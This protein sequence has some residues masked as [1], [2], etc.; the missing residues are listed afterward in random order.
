MSASIID[1]P[2]TAIT[3]APDRARAIDTVWAEGLARIIAAQGLRQ[4]ISVR[5]K[6]DGY[7]LVFG[8]HRLEAFRVLGRETIPAILSD[9]ADDDAAK[10]EEV[11]ENL[12]RQDLIALD[13]CH[14]LYDLKQVYERLFP[15]AKHGAKTGKGN[16]HVPAK[17]QSLPLSTDAKEILGFAKATADAIGLSER[18]IRLAVN[19]WVNLT[20]ATRTRLVGTDLA[21][22]QTELVALADLAPAK[23]GMVL[24]LILGE[25]PAKNVAQ[26]LAIIDGGL[27]LTD[28]EKQVAAASKVFARINDAVLDAVLDVHEDRIIASLKRRGRI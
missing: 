11:M 19:I 7:E 1:V 16:Q 18:A 23:Q 9:A 15:E 3:L 24:D 27:S 28:V 22:K 26:A 13:R 4:P 8:A 21:T 12:A 17:R 20:P 5:A 6:G 10:F 25:S 14:H 2:L